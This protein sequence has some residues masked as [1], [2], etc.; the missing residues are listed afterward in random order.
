MNVDLPSL[1]KAVEVCRLI[2]EAL[3]GRFHVALTGGS[4]YKDGPR[5][6]VDVIF[7]SHGNEELIDLDGRKDIRGG[8]RPG[9]ASLRRVP[10]LLRDQDEALYAFKHT[11]VT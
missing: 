9:S 7:L 5:K 4:L 10:V 1:S 8:S 11:G 2:E 3:N 6:D